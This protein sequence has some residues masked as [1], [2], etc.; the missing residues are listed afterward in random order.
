MQYKIGFATLLTLVS[1]SV[2]SG[3]RNYVA[4]IDQS[5]WNLETSSPLQCT[6]KHTIPNYGTAV[7]ESKAGRTMDL[8]FVLKM[9]RKPERETA[10][11]L[12][13]VAPSWRPGIPARDIVRLTYQPQFDAEVSKQ[14]AWVMLTEL[15]QGMQPTFYYQ[16]WYNPVDQVAVGLNAANF[17]NSYFE[18]VSCIDSLLPYGFE[19]IA[20]TV[21]NFR[22]RNGTLTPTSRK[23]LSRIKEFLSYDPNLELVLIDAYTDSFGGDAENMSISS[24]QAENL[25]QFFL[26]AG[27]SSDRIVTQSHGE[28]RHIATNS[29]ASGRAQNRRV[30][31]RME[32]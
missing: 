26:D 22:D 18:F 32:R 27:I 15:E 21:L 3:V 30:V 31:I 16:D 19:D 7:F 10:A 5:H 12:R 24:G 2:S 28:K 13:S 4:S 9:K 11:S 17:H 23:K 1:T 14:A 8:D 20:F 6:L 25:K 29:S